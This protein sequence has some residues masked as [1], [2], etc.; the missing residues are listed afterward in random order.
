MQPNTYIIDNEASLELK[1]SMKK[2]YI[3]F[4]LVSPH[5]HRANFAERAVQTYKSRL[6]ETLATADQDFPLAQWDSLIEQVNLTLN[7]LRSA[8]SN[9]KLSACAYLFGNFNVQATPLAPTGTRVVVYK[10][11]NIRTTWSSHSEDGWYVG[12][13]LEHYRCVSV[14]SPTTRT[15]RHVDTVHYF[16]NVVPFPKNNSRRP[17]PTS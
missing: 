11:K 2:E 9:P 14:F 15:V 17:S 12:P 4:Q 5:N 3:T 7:L 1:E 13:A 16:S 10:T 8:R 6:K